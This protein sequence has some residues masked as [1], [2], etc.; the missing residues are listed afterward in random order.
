MLRIGTERLSG[1]LG[2]LRKAAGLAGDHR[3]ITIRISIG[4][5]R[6]QYFRVECARFS[7]RTAPM[8]QQTALKEI[9]NR[10]SRHNRERQ[11]I[12][13]PKSIEFLVGIKPL[14]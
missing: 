8:Q 2:S 14:Q 12:A 3:Q 13:R 6:P 7:D 1:K 9:G 11:S 5:I 10:E 4:R